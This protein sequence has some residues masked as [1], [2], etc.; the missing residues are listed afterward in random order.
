ME[1]VSTK[2]NHWF[3][4]NFRWQGFSILSKELKA[5][6]WHWRDDKPDC[7]CFVRIPGT[8]TKVL[9]RIYFLDGTDL[10][11]TTDYSNWML[12]WL[13]LGGIE[14][15]SLCACKMTLICLTVLVPQRMVSGI[16]TRPNDRLKPCVSAEISW[17][18]HKSKNRLNLSMAKSL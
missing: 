12:H 5:E 8:F 2:W 11:T 15:Q 16:C 4:G 9:S 17:S 14:R 7:Y 10:S 1:W 3:H 13:M 18:P 6:N